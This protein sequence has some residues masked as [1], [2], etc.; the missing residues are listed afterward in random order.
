MACRGRGRK[1]RPLPRRVLL[2]TRRGRGYNEGEKKKNARDKQEETLMA[3]ANKKVLLPYD[4]QTVWEVVTSLTE[5]TWRSDIARIEILD[6]E[7]HHFVEYA[8]EEHKTTVT[9][10]VWQPGKRWE[11]DLRNDVMQGHWV[12]VFTPKDGGTLLDLTE[13]IKVKKLVMKLFIGSYLKMQQTQY[14]TD[15]KK[16]LQAAKQGG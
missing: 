10:T 12:G 13:D 9:T 16:A 5:Y 3:V 14:L 11:F 15:L 8:D 2:Y 1:N 4:V 6:A 7:A